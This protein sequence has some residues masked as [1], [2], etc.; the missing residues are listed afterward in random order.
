[1]PKDGAEPTP[2]AS[3]ARFSGRLRRDRGIERAGW[4]LGALAVVVAGAVVSGRLDSALPL[5][6]DTPA[7]TPSGPLATI[8]PRLANSPTPA[9]ATQTPVTPAVPCG[10]DDGRPPNASL[11]VGGAD[12]VIGDQTVL[13]WIGQPDATVRPP[14]N[15]PRVALPAEDKLTLVIEGERC[16]LAWNVVLFLERSLAQ[17]F[18]PAMDPA[19]AAQNRF[20]LDV[21]SMEGAE[22]TIEADLRFREGET[23]HTWRVVIE[24]VVVPD[25]RLG[26]A[27][28]ALGAL[29]SPGCGLVWTLPGG[30]GASVRCES[31]PGPLQVVDVAPGATLE[32]AVDGW[33]AET[34]ATS[35]GGFVGDLGPSFRADPACGQ[36]PASNERSPIEFAAPTSSGRWTI[37]LEAVLDSGVATL[38]GT[39]FVDI[40]VP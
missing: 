3:G 19:H 30:D 27:L 8:E 35:C 13:Q 17:Q 10:V 29:M 32:I 39:W 6:T 37:R 40:R 20:P 34:W 1:M 26:V 11:L 31:G 21:A 9:I 38:S 24:P 33:S 36:L 18:N 7:K 14:A 28:S 15:T 25:V 4:V 12:P 16:A 22:R 2:A 23:I 5:L